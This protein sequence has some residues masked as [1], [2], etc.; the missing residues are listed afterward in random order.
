MTSGL[1][2]QALEILV[3]AVFVIVI[4]VFFG[5]YTRARLQR[6]RA[7]LLDEL[8]RRPDLIQDRAFNRIAMARRE[9]E[10]LSKQGAEVG[11]AREEIAQAQAAFDNRRYE[12]AYEAAQRAHESLVHARRDR[13]SPLPSTS[14]VGVAQGP[15]DPAPSAPFPAAPLPV[16]PG[17][18]SPPPVA[19]NR[20]ESLFQLRLLDRELDAA[21]SGRPDLPSTSGAGHLAAEAHSAFDRADFTEAFRLALKGRRELGGPIESL[22]PTAGGAP[23][24]PGPL[25][26][27]GGGNG[28]ASPDAAD[29]AANV[30]GAERC[31]D[32]GY[33]T[34]SGEAFCRGCGR[35][36]GPSSC[37]QCGTARSP[38]DTI[39]GRCGAR[40]S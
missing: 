1:S 27:G 35:P 25:L 30:A 11:R 28:G 32:C 13:P 39:C 36:R 26:K 23:S 8:Q 19:K 18:T 24:G 6:R 29:T 22:P 33:P 20:A 40:F 38:D 31:P 17:P 15:S 2:S 9:S 14:P 37:P 5:L 16:A 3:V 7:Q 21:R 34:L 12:R 4:G 10:L